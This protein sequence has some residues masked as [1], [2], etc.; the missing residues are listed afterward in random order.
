MPD[1]LLPGVGLEPVKLRNRSAVGGVSMLVLSLI[2][3]VEWLDRTALACSPRHQSTWGER[4]VIGIIGGAPGVLLSS[5]HC[6]SA[7][8][9]D[10]H[11]S[12][13]ASFAAAWSVVVFATVS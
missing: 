4:R 11:R 2:V 8:L 5:R 6:R 1:D 3:V 7:T 12:K 13:V 9:A 10:Q